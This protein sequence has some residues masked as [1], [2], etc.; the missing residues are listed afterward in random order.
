MRK[1][2]YSGQPVKKK[3][4]A[5]LRYTLYYPVR[6]IILVEI[7]ALLRYTLYYPVRDRILVENEALLRY[8][9]YDPVRDNMWVETC[10]QLNIPSGII[11]G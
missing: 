4:E 3:F 9:L 5:L 1:H 10:Q 6:D 7:E 2:N 11:C 8:T